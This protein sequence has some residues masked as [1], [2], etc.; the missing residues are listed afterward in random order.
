MK[1]PTTRTSASILACGL[2]FTL[3]VAAQDC[4]F[5]PRG[6]GGLRTGTVFKDL[7]PFDDEIRAV[8]VQPDGKTVV[9]GTANDD[10]LIARFDVDGG[11]DDG[12]GGGD[13]VVTIDLDGR[14]DVEY[15]TDK[16]NAVAVLPTGRIL[17]A[18]TGGDGR[19]FD[20][21]VVALT[22]TGALDPEFAGNGVVLTGTSDAEYLKSIAVDPKGGFWVGGQELDEG[23]IR[24]DWDIMILKFHDDGR[25]DDYFDGNGKK[26]VSMGDE[27]IVGLVQALPNGKVMVAGEWHYEKEGYFVHRFD[28]NGA[29][30]SSLGLIG[31]VKLFFRSEGEYLIDFIAQ[32]DGSFFILTKK[33]IYAFDV[34]GDPVAT[35]GD[36]GVAT[37]D[38][39]DGRQNR[40]ASFVRLPGGKLAVAGAATSGANDFA[41]TQFF[42]NGEIDFT[43]GGGD[44]YVRQNVI[45]DWE[46]V[47]I[48][49]AIAVGPDGK[50]VVAGMTQRGTYEDTAVMR[51]HPDGTLD[52][53]CLELPE[54]PEVPG[55]DRGGQAAFRRGDANT[56]GAVDMTDAIYTLDFLFTGKEEPACMDA[57]DANDDAVVDLSDATRMLGFLFLGK[58]APPAPFESCGRSTRKNGSGCG[59][60]DGCTGRLPTKDLPGDGI[61]R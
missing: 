4:G 50:L 35:F 17:V 36:N 43:F 5:G 13:G 1:F 37:I 31:H 38:Q 22:P 8:A 47:D 51:F 16:A 10:F 56:N 11:L 58:A 29:R 30:D 3:P 26:K 27:E 18:G 41:I 61:S 48:P 33:A 20:Y 24:S 12:F 54:T 28:G 21:A 32:D 7:A 52:Q 42:A 40:A 45:L 19:D 39:S 55:G 57:L 59:R 6:F 25:L 44:G 2:I 49:Q 14:P 53:D 9:V 60:Y 15:F 34:W 46:I 23:I